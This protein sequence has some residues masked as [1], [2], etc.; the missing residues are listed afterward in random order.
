MEGVRSFCEVVYALLPILLI[1]PFRYLIDIYLLLLYPALPPDSF[2]A[3][4][5]RSLWQ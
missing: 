3:L 1:S 2:V 4:L 5:V